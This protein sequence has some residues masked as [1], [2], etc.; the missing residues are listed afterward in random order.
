MHKE[1]EMAI[2]TEVDDKIIMTFEQIKNGMFAR[3]ATKPISNKNPKFDPYSHSF[4]QTAQEK[5]IKFS[6]EEIK[7]AKL[8]RDARRRIGSTPPRK[9][10]KSPNQ[11]L[12]MSINMNS[13][14]AR[15]A[16]RAN[17]DGVI[18]P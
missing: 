6:A 14:N 17:T 8:A 4:V 12:I 5:S 15:R 13:L 18:K 7:L 9:F 3:D 11:G 16:V 10:S 1:V 2:W